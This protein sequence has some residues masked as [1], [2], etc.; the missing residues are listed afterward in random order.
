MKI[1]I[2]SFLLALGMV[3]TLGCSGGATGDAQVPSVFKVDSVVSTNGQNNIESDMVNATDGV[4]ADYATVT[5]SNYLKNPSATPSHFNDVTITGYKVEFSRTDGGTVF[6]NFTGGLSQTVTVNSTTTFNVMVVRLQEKTSGALAGTLS[7]YEMTAKITFNGKN[8]SGQYVDAVGSIEVTIANYGNDVDPLVPAIGSF[9]ADKKEGVDGQDVALAWYV[10]GDVNELILNPGD[11]HLTPAGY[12]PYGTYTI[13]NV[14]FPQTFTLVAMGIFGVTSESVDIDE[15]TTTPMLPTINTFSAQPASIGSGQSATLSWDV[16]DATSVTIYPGIGTVASTSGETTVSPQFSTTYTLVAS[17]G[18]GVKTAVTALTVNN[19]EPEITLFTGSTDSVDAGSVAHLYWTI[20]G[21]YTKAELFPFYNQADD[22]LDVTHQ[23]SAVTEPINVDT[24]F[25]LTA[26]GDST[27]VNKTFK[28]KVNTTKNN[29]VKI[30][31]RTSAPGSLSWNVEDLAQSAVS[32]RLYTID[33]DRL[34]FNRNSGSLKDGNGLISVNYKILSKGFG[35]S[36]VQLVAVDKDGSA[37]NHY[38]LVQGSGLCKQA[39]SLHFD[40]N[41]PIIR[42][43]TPQQAPVSAFTIN[44]PADMAGGSVLIK[45]V[46]G[47]RDIEMK[48]SDGKWVSLSQGRFIPV[49]SARLS[50]QLRDDYRSN[51][52]PEVALLILAR[53]ENGQ[54]AGR[55]ITLGLR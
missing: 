45:T 35:Y 23:N 26:Y 2:F 42:R 10:T 46:S 5:V 15:V 49:D 39:N 32:Y 54:T 18:D 41:A 29:A 6:A 28:I 1:K 25:V 44:L 19:S 11:I 13:H 30:A 3:F 14:D 38:S 52:S 27:V 48:T 33:G 21:S 8:G 51:L 4:T 50:I 53:G 55:V 20:Q 16:S 34:V 43:A 9:F 22:I 37:V 47:E 7:P 40:T 36:V 31:D 24:T 17:N 12:Y